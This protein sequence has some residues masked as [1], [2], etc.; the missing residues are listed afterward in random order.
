MRMSGLA[1]ISLGSYKNS[2]RIKLTIIGI[3]FQFALILGLHKEGCARAVIAR[4]VSDA[5]IQSIFEIYSY[6]WIAPLCSQ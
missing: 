6:R 2:L 3:N 1:N 4:S 5:A